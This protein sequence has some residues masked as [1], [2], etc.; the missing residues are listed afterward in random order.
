MNWDTSRRERD[1]RI[2]LGRWSLRTVAGVSDRSGWPSSEVIATGSATSAALA[3]KAATS[4]IPIVFML[5]MDPVEVGLVASLS[6]PGVNLTGVTTLN[7]EIVPKRL[8]VL[9]VLL[10]ATNIMAVLVNPINYRGR[11]RQTR[12][13]SVR[14]QNSWT[15]DH[16]HPRGDVP[17]ASRESGTFCQWRKNVSLVSSY[18]RTLCESSA[19]ALCQAPVAER[20]VALPPARRWSCKCGS[21]YSP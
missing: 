8:E 2:S 11:S 12:N 18:R 17:P 7:V 4:A 9:R 15:G 13:R 14:R 3:V 1:Y 20:P 5:G 21:R 6:R 16:P 19:A 10:P